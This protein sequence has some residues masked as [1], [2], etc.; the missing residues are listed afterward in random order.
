MGLFSTANAENSVGVGKSSLADGVSSLALG[1]GAKATK[2]RAVAIGAGSVANVASTVSVGSNAI[3][4]RIV[5]LAS[6]VGTN[7]AV[8]VG[9]LQAAM[10]TVAA[11]SNGVRDTNEDIR[12]ELA[13]L[14]ALVERQLALIDGQQQRIARFESIIAAASLK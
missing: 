9:Q 4:R 1:A 11:G 10:A 2:K 5:N 13:A 3:K 14:R 8:T 12:R 6:G 7:D